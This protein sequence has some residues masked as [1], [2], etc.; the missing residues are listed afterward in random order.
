M[1]VSPDP[2]WQEVAKSAE[3]SRAAKLA[4]ESASLGWAVVQARKVMS[5]WKQRYRKRFRG[6]L[7]RCGGCHGMKP[8]EDF[9]KLKSGY[10]QSRCRACRERVK[11]KSRARK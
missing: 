6:G 9:T 11:A 7:V 4:H 5:L 1:G 10:L 8:P 3:Q 2:Y